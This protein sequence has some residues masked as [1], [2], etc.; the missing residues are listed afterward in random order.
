VGLFYYA[1]HGLQVKG[2]NFLVPVNAEIDREDEIEFTT[3]DVNIVL[4]KMDSAKNA[5]NIVIL[6]ACRNNPF[7]RSFRSVSRGLAQM[8]APTGTFIAFATAPGS[9]ASDGT[10]QNGLYTEHLLREMQKPGVPIEQLFKQIRIGVMQDTNSQQIPWE[11]SSMRGD[12]SFRAGVPV[13]A[14]ASQAVV[15]EAVA[16]ALKREREAQQQAMEKMIAAALDKQRLMLEAQ[17]VKFQPP[18][19]AGPDPRE[20]ELKAAAERAA[21]ERAAADKALAEAR[22]AVRKAEVEK[23]AA[24]TA[25][26]ELAA[27]E[28]AAAE[29]TAAAKLA[30]DR[31]AAERLAAEKAA[32]DKATAARLATERAAAERLAAE[33]AAAD[34]AAAAKLAADRAAAE[35][36]A[37]EKAAAEQKAT[38]ERAAAERAAAE[39]QKAEKIQLASAAPLSIAA[40]GSSGRLPT[41]G[42]TWTYRLT[43]PSRTQGTR[44]R[45]YTATI[46]AATHTA[47]LENYT[48]GDGAPGEWAHQPGGYLVGLVVPQFSPYMA[49]FQDLSPGARLKDVTTVGLNGCNVGRIACSADGKVVLKETVTVAAGTFDAIKVSVEQ[50]WLPRQ[51]GSGTAPGGRTI[52]LWYAPQVKRVVKASSRVIGY[53]SGAEYDLELVSY[54]VK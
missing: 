16:E 2:R 43:E 52:T 26:A 4:A 3:L 1:G 45:A 15:A 33:R 38:S 39:K 30:A 50:V 36:L 19:P 5:L 37:A 51:T 41:I 31:A 13:A 25:A 35:R 12:F 8:D 28:K 44:Q 49:A 29:R 22:E 48:V 10:G 32:A 53:Y 20:K 21:A 14:A 18:A 11:S 7:A 24:Q 34:K 47:I 42:D 9:V 6:D 17:G 27:A 40:G 46:V 54:Q 23:L